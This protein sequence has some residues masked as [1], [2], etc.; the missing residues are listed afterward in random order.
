MRKDKKEQLERAGW[1]VG[2]VKDFLRLTD[3][4]MAVIHMRV[5]QA[6]KR[7]AKV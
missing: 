4:D 7:K 2:D 1:K 5:S 6:P 3:A